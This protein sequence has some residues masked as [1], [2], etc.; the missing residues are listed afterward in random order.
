VPIS[1]A[2]CPVWPGGTG[3]FWDDELR[4]AGVDSATV[5]VVRY[6][7]RLALFQ[8]GVFGEIEIEIVAQAT[9]AFWEKWRLEQAQAWTV[10]VSRWDGSLA[11]ALDFPGT[12]Q[13]AP[14]W[15]RGQRDD[16]FRSAN[17]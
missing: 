2:D 12:W 7:A 14:G 16:T 15:R 10:L 9:R 3:D 5:G 11:R 4:R 17:Y 6:S 8:F 1:L 13:D